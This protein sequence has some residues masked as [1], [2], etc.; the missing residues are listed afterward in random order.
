MARVSQ[1]RILVS[2]KG[3]NTIQKDFA[4]GE[5]FEG[6]ENLSPELRAEQ[7][8]VLALHPLASTPN[9]SFIPPS[10][11]ESRKW[12][13]PGWQLQ[14]DTPL[15][16]RNLNHDS[17]LPAKPSFP[18]LQTSLSECSS[19]P[20]RQ[21]ASFLN[22]VHLRMLTTPLS[23]MSQSCA[24]AEPYP[25]GFAELLDGENLTSYLPL[26]QKHSHAYFN[27]R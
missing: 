4:K 27:F 25:T 3:E 11:A 14:L 15:V 26:D 19:G 13:E 24:P 1:K 8:L 20:G 22:P 17:I 16:D 2:N 9:L 18:L 12:A 6:P 5:T 23:I 21:A 10:A 7:L